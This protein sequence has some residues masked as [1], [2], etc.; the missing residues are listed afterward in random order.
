[1]RRARDAYDQ[2]VDL[3]VR[4]ARAQYGLLH[5]VGAEAGRFRIAGRAGVR[6]DFVL[7]GRS[8]GDLCCSLYSLEGVAG[9]AGGP[10]TE[11]GGS[12][13]CVVYLHGNCGCRA[14]ANETV[15]LLLPA[16]LQVC[17]FDFTACG[18]SPGDYVTLGSQEPQDLAIVIEFLRNTGVG[19][20]ALW[21]RSMGAVT[22]MRYV[23]TCRDHSIAA[24]VADSP[25][26]S[27]PVLMRE[28]SSGRSAIPGFIIGFAISA[29]TRSIQRRAGFD[30]NQVDTL[31]SAR[32]CHM[33]ALLAHGL[34]DK[35]IPPE[36]ADRLYSC[37]AGDCRLMTFPGDHNDVRPI[38]FYHAARQLLVRSLE[39]GLKTA[40]SLFQG[41]TLNVD[42]S[43]RSEQGERSPMNHMDSD[44]AIQLNRL[45]SVR[46]TNHSRSSCKSFPGDWART[47]EEEQEQGDGPGAL[48][49]Q[50]SPESSKSSGEDSPQIASA[51]IN[52]RGEGPEEGD[53]REGRPGGG[54]PAS[55][56]Q[57]RLWVPERDGMCEEDCP[58]LPLS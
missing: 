15:K 25:F 6:K 3:V 54:A 11:P 32:G 31:Q 23:D 48:E 47:G 33:P 27:L 10:D 36:H 46:A 19:Q 35:L 9:G 42:I 22:T 18:H 5:L 4:P 24:I 2:L 12:P 45:S 50:P 17:C 16:G 49:E 58:P 41:L 20:I 53:S 26:S 34:N 38:E 55:G 39:G 51:D 40:T 28:V 13:P 14:D 7:R 57:S 37:Y 29:L 52:T 44:R 43:G 56:S 1:M 8:G 21:G 30:I